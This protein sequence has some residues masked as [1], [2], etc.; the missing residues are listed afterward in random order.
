MFSVI[1]SSRVMEPELEPV[2]R[3][4]EGVEIRYVDQVLLCTPQKVGPLIQREIDRVED[5]ATQV[6]L[7][8]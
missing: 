1:V 3:C 4:E 5:F 6:V 7:G 8:Y 2:H